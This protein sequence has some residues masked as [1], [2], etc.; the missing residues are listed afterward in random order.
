MQTVVL[1]LVFFGTTLVLFGAYVFAN[2]RRLEAT[3]AL[4]ARIG[5]TTARSP[6]P[7]LRDL[8][9]SAV[10]MLDRVLTG[11]SFTVL[12]EVAIERAGLHWTVGEFTIASA[13][14]ASM[15]LLAA[16][17]FGVAAS[18]A[19]ATIG[20]VLPTFLLNVQRR[21]RVARIEEQLPEAIDMIV[22]AMRA[23]FSFQAAMKFV[24]EEMAAPIGEEFATFYEEQRLGLDV[25]DAL[26][27]L[28]ERIDTL[29]IKMFVTS[30]LI[31]RETGGNLGEILTGLST[32]IRD[33]AALRDQIDTL[34]AEP[35][36]TGTAL[37]LLP[38]LAFAVIMI[39]NRPMMQPMFDTE[40]GR[41]TLMFAAGIL[42]VGF[43]MIRRIAR[44][45]M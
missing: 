26:L 5:A 13:L 19:A 17:S 27:D 35:K 3:A 40:T 34:T 42:T 21:R 29:D 43:L 4:K 24:G 37:A 39:L 28:Q 15:G 12:I 11:R 16:Q 41:Y 22:N 36:L 18:L 9:K 14:L 45:D 30:L 25:R 1:F 10:P 32:L 8:R 20:L 23:G 7:I 33:R 2:R 44:I 6:T 38:L 31:Q